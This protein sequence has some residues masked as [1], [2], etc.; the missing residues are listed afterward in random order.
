MSQAKTFLLLFLIE[1]CLLILELFTDRKNCNYSRNAVQLNFVFPISIHGSWILWVQFTQKSDFLAS[2]ECLELAD[3]VR[4]LTFST[5]ILSDTMNQL[6]VSVFF[7]FRPNF[8]KKSSIRFWEKS[9]SIVKSLL[10][11]FAR[12]AKNLREG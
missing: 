9:P 6:N 10:A 2:K 4:A 3:V 7:Y 5:K 12:S 8:F 1:F 11:V